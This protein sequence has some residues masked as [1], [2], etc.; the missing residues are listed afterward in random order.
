MKIGIPLPEV[1]YEVTWP[2]P[3]VMARTVEA[4]GPDS[5]WLGDHLLCDIAGVG[6]RGPWAAWTSLAALA[7]VTDR[8]Q[9][10][11]LVA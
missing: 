5:I 10:G 1:E 11:L 9:L 6:P 7:A 8:V 2:D 3:I 4:V